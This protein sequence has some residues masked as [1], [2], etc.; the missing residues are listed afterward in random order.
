MHC[1]VTLVLVGL[2]A[3]LASAPGTTA[4]DSRHP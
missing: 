4:P 1:K 2:Q 3:M